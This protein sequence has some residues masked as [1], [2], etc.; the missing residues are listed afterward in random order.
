MANKASNEVLIQLAVSQFQGKDFR[1]ILVDGDFVYD[2]AN[3][4]W[5]QDVSADELAEGSNYFTGGLD[6][7]NMTI[8]EYATYIDV[9]WD[10]V[11][12]EALGGDVGPTN[13]ALIICKTDDEYDEYDAEWIAGYIEF[14]ASYTIPEDGGLQ[15]TIPTVRFLGQQVA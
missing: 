4:R 11:V 15:I 12:F 13:G 6:L 2:V 10:T 9:A 7:E 8:T 1:I 3:H 5:Y 14:P